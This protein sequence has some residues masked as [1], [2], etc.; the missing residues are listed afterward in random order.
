[1]NR[2]KKC[3]GDF[4]SHEI[5]EHNFQNV[6]GNIPPYVKQC[7]N[8]EQI[9]YA[10]CPACDNPIEIIG[11]YK[12]TLESGRQPYGRHHDGTILNLAEYD[13]AEYYD[14]PYSKP[15]K[16]NKTKYRRPESK[17]SGQIYELLRMQFDRVI[18]LLGKSADMKISNETAGRMLAEYLGDKGYC[19]RNATMHNLPWS[20]AL[21]ALPKKLFGRKIV[22]G[23]EFHKEMEVRC[24]DVRFDGEP[25]SKYVQ[26]K[27]NGLHDAELFYNFYNLRQTHKTE[28]CDTEA[29]TESIDFVAY[30]S[31]NSEGNVETAY[32]KTI[33]IEPEYFMNLVLLPDEKAKRNEQLLTIANDLML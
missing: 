9:R 12:N 23:S 28:G 16:N 31:R 17:I 19:Y 27:Y 32:K 15:G 14:C 25:N 33:R 1:M 5:N 22:R 30:R 6:T 26:L 13:E 8:E 2:F 3:V 24:P 10:V 4:R 18:F 11:L 21:A 7:P 29:I 20:F